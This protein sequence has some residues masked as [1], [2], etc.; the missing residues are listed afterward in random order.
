MSPRTNLWM[1]IV[2]GIGAT[3]LSVNA[4]P[5]RFAATAPSTAPSAVDIARVKQ[6][7]EQ[8][9]DDDA[10]VRQRAS[11][12]LNSLDGKCF[13]MVEAASQRP[14]ISPESKERLEKALFYLRPRSRTQPAQESRAA[15]LKSS[16]HE[17]YENSGDKNP[18][19][20]DIAHR[21]IDLMIPLGAD[22]LH[23]SRSIRDQAMRALG[24]A[25]NAGCDDPFIKS[26]YG[27][28]VGRLAGGASSFGLGGG[29][30]GAQ[31]EVQRR[32]DLRLA[33]ISQRRRAPFAA[34]LR[35]S[36]GA[37]GEAREA[38]GR[39]RRRSRCT[40]LG[41]LSCFEPQQR[42]LAKF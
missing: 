32:Q 17:A 26:L 8:L 41:L 24:D 16:L 29:L 42:R 18:A 27:M 11:L 15:W 25:I 9:D 21:G 30:D 34:G 2:A 14:D 36:R 28:C 4:Q 23:G 10:A 3:V 38:T 20:D 22:P 6:I 5:S 37:A 12:Q 13:P 7:I 33:W 31:A 19:Y 35:G 40:C 39:A 1:F